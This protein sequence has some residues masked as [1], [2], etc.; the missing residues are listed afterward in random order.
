MPIKDATEVLSGDY[1]AGESA[2]PQSAPD[3][4]DCSMHS[5]A[6][7]GLLFMCAPPTVPQHLLAA[8]QGMAMRVNEWSSGQGRPHW[9][10][11]M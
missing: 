4:W 5:D 8:A 7:L 6:A 10:Q 2:G 9:L 3:L 1:V 11:W